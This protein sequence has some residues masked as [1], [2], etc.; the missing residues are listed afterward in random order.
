MTNKEA[1][2][3]LRYVA[4]F[5]SK[6]A[7][8]IEDFIDGKRDKIDDEFLIYLNGQIVD[9]QEKVINYLQEIVL[10]NGE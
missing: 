2:E 3:H 5:A 6:M 4:I 8:Q 9:N 1:V 7:D 10:E